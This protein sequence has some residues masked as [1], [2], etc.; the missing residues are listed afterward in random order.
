MDGWKKEIYVSMG[1]LFIVWN[2][3]NGW[4]EKIIVV[5]GKRIGG[6]VRK[7][8]LSY[9][10]WLSWVY[11]GK[12]IIIYIRWMKIYGWK[13]FNMFGFFFFLLW[14]GMIWVEL[15]EDDVI[16]VWRVMFLNLFVFL[17]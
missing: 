6:R 11:L 5:K 4:K 12:F 13:L 2:M 16:Y 7:K 14:V 8:R 3:Y 10:L 15:D 17:F 1:N 9:F